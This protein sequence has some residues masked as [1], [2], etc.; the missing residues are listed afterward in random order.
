[1]GDQRAHHDAARARFHQP[2]W[3][4]LL[5]WRGRGQA[6]AGQFSRGHGAEKRRQFL[7]F[8]PASSETPATNSTVQQGSLE[9]SNVNPVA[10]MV[11]LITAQR[12]AE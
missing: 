5:E 10:S 1:M 7:L 3:N 4:H 8:R 9:N 2:R 11:E 12:S 6:T